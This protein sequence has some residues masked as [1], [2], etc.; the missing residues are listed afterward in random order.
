MMPPMPGMWNWPE[1][2]S[3]AEKAGDPDFAGYK[4]VA[5]DGEI[6]HVRSFAS[7]PDESH[8]I[9]DTGGWL[10]GR[11]SLIPAG[12]VRVVD[13]ESETVQI[14]LTKQQ[15]EDA[16]EYD[17]DAGYADYRDRAGEYFGGMM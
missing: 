4:V 15:I 6:G 8:L 7:A 1:P 12:A 10:L 11:L 9:V 17:P 5:N 13:H 2:G 14:D 16:P 3:E